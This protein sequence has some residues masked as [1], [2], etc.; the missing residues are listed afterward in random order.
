MTM[1]QHHMFPILNSF[2]SIFTPTLRSL[3]FQGYCGYYQFLKLSNLTSFT[4][5]G[6]TRKISAENFHEFLL[7]NRWSLETLSLDHVKLEGSLD[8][9]LVVL[10]NLKSFTVKHPR[11]HCLPWLSSVISVPVFERLSSLSFSIRQEET[12]WLTLH[13]IGD[14][15]VFTVDT[16][17][18][19]V[20]ETWRN[21][22]E[23]AKPIIKRVR[24]E[25]PDDIDYHGEAGVV[26]KLF[27]DASILEIG[28]GCAD[29]YPDFWDGLERLGPQLMIIR[30]E[31]PGDA[32]GFPGL[33]KD[34]EG[35]IK[36]M[37]N[38]RLPLPLVQRLVIDE[39]GSVNGWQELA[40]KLFSEGHLSRYRYK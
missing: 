1:T 20:V 2:L 25:N 36:R 3:S 15:I 12:Y 27:M 38:S 10:S 31:L 16:E 21:L 32:E 19:L 14:D 28:H 39:N 30:F 23:H 34:I 9:E 4:I 26:I 37:Y 8:Q 11:T 18:N 29:L 5:S 24:F 40:W 22:T 6:P 35:L 13:A 33:L 17:H 7:N